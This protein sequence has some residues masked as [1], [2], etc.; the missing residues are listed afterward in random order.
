M[1]SI[2]AARCLRLIIAVSVGLLSIYGCSVGPRYH[3]PA[4]VAP[5][6]WQS[7]TTDTEQGGATPATEAWPA[8]DWWQGFGSADLNEY[9]AEAQASNDDLHAAVARI[10][11]ADAQLR[12]A[13]A[14]LLP[15][16]DLGAAATRERAQVSGAGVRTFNIFNPQIT[17]AY[18]LDFWGKN[19]AARDAASAAALASRFDRQTIALTVISSVAT[20]YFQA[21]G[22]RDRI[23]VGEENL[24]NGEKVLRGLR[25]QQ[26]AGIVT[27]LDVAQQDTTVA[28]LSAA[29]P[30]LRQQYQQNVHALAV[31]LGRTPESIV[32]GEGTLT[33]LNLPP[34]LDGLPSALL[35]RR[36]DI[37]EAEQ[38]LIQAN[39]DVTVAKAAL[40][41]TIQ[42]TV[43]GG[44]ESAALAGLFNPAN[45]FFTVS[46]G[47]TQPIFHGGALRGQLALNRARYDEL[48]A[49]Y[50]KAVLTAFSNVEDAL[51]AAQ[52][53]ME[54]TQRQQDAVD[55]ARRAYEFSQTQMKAGI[56][57]ILTV[58]NTENA[59]FSA[60]DELVQTQA[61][62]AQALVN[63]FT[64][65]GG[66]WQQG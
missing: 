44:F 6:R 4:F 23:R 60:Q 57:D 42:L 43:S 10:R 35:T 45:R 34:V 17:A 22:L 41:P 31:L 1:S 18:E 15:S 53:T 25:Q 8:A 13:G 12:I 52:Q 11:E 21:L 9:I 56:V 65:L 14:T 47:L 5:D 30:P 46:A 33:A 48:V 40:F 32:V 27:G 26:M 54:Q 7:T 66:G 16:A 55:K 64:A 61:L 51:V 50:H 29:L 38:N 39:A 36:P 28:L 20:T 37:A 49:N 62:R 63:L 58:L 19:R 3:R 2:L 59:L 24:R